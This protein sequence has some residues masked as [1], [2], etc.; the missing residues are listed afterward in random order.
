[1]E[2]L[3]QRRDTDRQSKPTEPQAAVLERAVQKLVLV[4][5]GVGLCV[6]D[7]IDLL[8]SGMTVGEL[9]DHIGSKLQRQRQ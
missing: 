8:D 4:A 6:D 1:M 5:A 2:G 9:L 3:S 7:L